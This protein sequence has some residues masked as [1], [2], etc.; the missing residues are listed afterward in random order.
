MDWSEDDWDGA[1]YTRE[2]V[3][4][5]AAGEDLTTEDISQAGFGE[6]G[7]TDQM[8]PG[9]ALAALVHAATTD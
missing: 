3:A 7:V 4:A 6:D 5:V 8:Y 9:P 2:L 1:A